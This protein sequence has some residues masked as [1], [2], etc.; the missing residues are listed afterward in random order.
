MVGNKWFN[1]ILQ[2]PKWWFHGD[3]NQGKTTVQSIF[4]HLKLIQQVWHMSI[5]DR[6]RAVCRRLV[7]GVFVGVFVEFFFWL[8]QK[9]Q[10]SWQ[11]WDGEFTGTQTQRLERW[12]STEVKKVTN[13]ITWMLLLGGWATQL[14]NMFVNFYIISPNLRWFQ[15]SWWFQ[16]FAK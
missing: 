5:L 4:H 1:Y 6:M 2:N 16:P 14:K 7:E 13:W 8:E 10:S 15:P 12:P 3:I 11:F 9:P